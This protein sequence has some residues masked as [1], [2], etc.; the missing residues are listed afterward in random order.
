[1]DIPPIEGASAMAIVLGQNNYGKSRV[2]IVKV[3]KHPDR[4]DLAEWDIAIQLQGDFLT[5]HT[6]GDN[7]KLLPTDTMKNTVYALAKGDPT[8]DGESLGLKLAGHF[9][10]NNPQVT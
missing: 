8:A 5:A 2:R 7:S 3:T 10:T 9:L 6:H 1:M 4:H